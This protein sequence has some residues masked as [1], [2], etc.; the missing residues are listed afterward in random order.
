MTGAALPPARR[1]PLWIGIPVFVAA[2]ALVSIPPGAGRRERAGSDVNHLFALLDRQGHE[3][4]VQPGDVPRPGDK[5]KVFWSSSQLTQLAVLARTGDGQVRC[6]F[7]P[8]GSQSV[9][10][11]PVD[12]R[13]LG[14]ALLVDEHFSGLRLW[15]VVAR[16]AFAVA[17]LMEE[18]R[19]SGTLRPDPARQVLEL[20]LPAVASSEPDR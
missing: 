4:V 8:D 14:S 9:A 10:M 17:P 1:S 15:G 11:N 5:A 12:A 20:T 7:P 13:E 16:S 2:L 6:F 3:N 19:G 18:L